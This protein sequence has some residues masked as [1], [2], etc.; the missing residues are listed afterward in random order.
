M[1]KPG[2]DPVWIP[3]AQYE[4]ITAHVPI[5]CVDLIPLS[6]EGLVGLIRRETYEGGQ[7]WCLVG[8]AVRRNESLLDAVLRHATS[9]LEM[10]HPLDPA[11]VQRFQ[12]FEYFT[13]RRRGALYDPRKH[14]ISLTHVAVLKGSVSAS[15][16]GEALEFRWFT[17]ASLQERGLERQT[18]TG[19]GFGQGRVVAEVLEALADDRL[20]RLPALDRARSATAG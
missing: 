11:A 15:A 5:A 13:V 6:P 20:S 7:G 2:S 10:R 16:G 19:F 4:Y 1:T 3:E 8:G 9:D 12:V 17:P 18:G 14:A